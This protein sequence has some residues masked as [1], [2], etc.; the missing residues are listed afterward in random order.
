MLEIMC[1]MRFG[2]QP[3][4]LVLV[5]HAAPPVASFSHTWGRD[6]M[7]DDELSMTAVRQVYSHLRIY[8]PISL[9]HTVHVSSRKL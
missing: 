4:A 3:H 6:V 9:N 5:R 8:H 2:L 1:D 7:A